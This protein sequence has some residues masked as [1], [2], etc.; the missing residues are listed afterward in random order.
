MSIFLLIYFS[1]TG[2][3]NV[4]SSDFVS[5]S[6]TFPG[7]PTSFKNIELSSE[8]VPYFDMYPENIAVAFDVY[9]AFA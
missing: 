8:S 2:S 6:S 9:F 7:S 4:V 5:S 1:I 3:N